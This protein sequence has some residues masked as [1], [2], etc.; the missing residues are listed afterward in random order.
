MRTGKINA[1]A[2]HLFPADIL[3][4]WPQNCRVCITTDESFRFHYNELDEI[5]C[6]LDS[7]ENLRSFEKYSTAR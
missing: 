5:P 6:Q 3:E 1:S 7:T 2:R 4:R